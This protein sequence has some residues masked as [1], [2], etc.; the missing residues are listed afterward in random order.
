MRIRFRPYLGAVLLLACS[1]G[2]APEPPPDLPP[3]AG[4]TVHEYAYLTDAVEHFVRFL[5][6]REALDPALVDDSV[7]LH[8]A[9]EGGGG[10]R[11]LAR[12]ELTE[13]AAWRVGEYAFVPPAALPSKTVAPGLHFSCMPGSLAEV[14]PDLAP[15]PHVG[16]RL[17]ASDDASCLQT[18]NATFVFSRDPERPRLVAVV[19]DQWEW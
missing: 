16:V 9:P 13:A 3:A 1:R 19:Y 8:V 15:L 2:A 5:Q 18:W 17:A 12:H 6:G 7:A 14:Q 10:L 4:G 11:R